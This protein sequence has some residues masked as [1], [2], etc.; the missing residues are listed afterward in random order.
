MTISTIKYSLLDFLLYVIFLYNYSTFL[1]YYFTSRAYKYHSVALLSPYTLGTDCSWFRIVTNIFYSSQQSAI[2]CSSNQRTPSSS[3]HSLP[4]T[5]STQEVTPLQWPIIAFFSGDDADVV[6]ATVTEG[7]TLLDSWQW[8]CIRGL[9][10]R[11]KGQVLMMASSDMGRV[12][13]LFI[14]TDYRVSFVILRVKP[15][16]DTIKIS[17]NL[18]HFFQVRKWR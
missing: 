9:Q 16:L 1:A 14:T 12:W 11:R 13:V 15:D 18:C 17:T 7:N 6:W 8:K 4:S 3:P 10:I 5:P 2:W